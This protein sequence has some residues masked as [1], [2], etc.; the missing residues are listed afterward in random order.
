MK[1]FLYITFL[2]LGNQLFSQIGINTENPRLEVALDVNTIANITDRIYIGNDQLTQIGDEGQN[3]QVIV[4]G[5][6]DGSVEW[7]SKQIPN[8]F[9]ASFTMTSMNTYYD[10]TGVNLASNGSIGY[11]ETNTLNDAYTAVDTNFASCTAGNCWRTLNGLTNTFTVYKP[12]NKINFILQT[13]AQIN[14]ANLSSFACALFLN[15][16]SSPSVFTMKGVRT[17]I[18]PGSSQGNYQLFNMNVTLEGLATPNGAGGTVYEARVACRGRLVGSDS[19]GVGKPIN[20]TFLNQDMA[21][22]TLNVFVL[23]SW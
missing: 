10:T 9:G 2:F 6:G 19:F 5:G 7:N 14:S 23:E 18:I 16:P 8:G 20:N 17:D 11:G 4:S 1:L 21:Q 3:K 22:S 13:T 15:S 12:G